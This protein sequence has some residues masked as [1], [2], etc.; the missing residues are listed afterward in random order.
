MHLISVTI[1]VL[2][3]IFISTTSSQDCKGCASLDE[4][5][6]DK[7]VSRFKASIVKF[8]VAYPY[9]DKHNVFAKF[10]EE[11]V[12]NKDILIAQVGVKDYGDK[13]NE[14][15]SKKYGVKS[16][17]D[18][19]VI[20]LFVEGKRDPLFYTETNWDLDTLRTFAKT[21]T[22]VYIGLPG[23]LEKYDQL[24]TNFVKS[25]D[26]AQAVSDAEKLLEQEKE[27]KEAAETYVKYMKKVAEQGNEFV[28]LE[29]A[30]LAKI[31][32]EGKIKEKKK[33]ELS[34][35]INILH[36]FAIEPKDEL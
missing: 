21:N 10:A 2:C 25:S 31:I 19:P 5:N 28:K 34:R 14:E 27:D 18:L 3:L 7:V 9:G 35:R 36:S 26:K 16:R 12:T 6:F 24:A 13:E 33:E 22:K 11:M 30:R 8:D 4:H 1:T 15:L 32:K 17:D 29:L 23:C 20:L